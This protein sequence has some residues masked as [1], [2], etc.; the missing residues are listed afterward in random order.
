VRIRVHV[1]LFVAAI[2]GL[3]G[4]CLKSVER[5]LTEEHVQGEITPGFPEGWLL[6]GSR[7]GQQAFDSHGGFDSEIR[8]GGSYSASFFS[9]NVSRDDQARLTQRIRA[10][11]LVGKR[12]RFSGYVKTNDVNGWAGL[13]MRVDTW[14]K[15]AWAFDDME[16]RGITGT[17]EWARYQVVLDVPEDAAAIYFGAHFFGRGQVWLDDC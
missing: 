9:L 17:T 13:W 3:S 2:A 14:D 11:H 7:D 6:Y 12:V 10:T 16:D 15:Q 8:H 5:G 4:A 1:V